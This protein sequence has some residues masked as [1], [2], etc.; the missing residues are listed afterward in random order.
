MY[1]IE[2]LTVMTGLTDRTVRNYIRQGFLQG[3]QEKG[4]WLFSDE[5]LDTFFSHPAVVPALQAKRNSVVFDFLKDD[6]KQA[7]E[8][9]VILD[10]PKGK[11]E[12]LSGFFCNAVNESSG[13]KMFFHNDRGNVRVILSGDMQNVLSVLA[14]YQKLDG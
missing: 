2:D 5:N 3:Q 7:E 13:V 12:D 6:K 4:K 8:I 9:C 11:G 1:T 14:A 10:W